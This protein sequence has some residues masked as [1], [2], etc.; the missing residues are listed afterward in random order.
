ML[1]AGF[2]TVVP[3]YWDWIEYMSFLR[4]AFVALM[5]NEFKGTGPAGEQALA[6]LELESWNVWNGVVGLV[7]QLIIYRILALVAF[8]FVHQEKR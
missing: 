2:F 6:L 4:W 7:C 3:V 1:F 8:R 5:V